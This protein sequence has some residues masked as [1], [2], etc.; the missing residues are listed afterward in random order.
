MTSTAGNA[1]LS[2]SGPGHLSNGAYSLSQPLQVAMTPAAW[3]GPVSNATVAVT[4]KQAIGATE[5]LRTGTYSR[6]LTFTLATT[7]P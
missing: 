6:T 3:S 4:F 1:T 7:E 5:A 2:V